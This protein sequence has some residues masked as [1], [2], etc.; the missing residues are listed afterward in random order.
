[1]ANKVGEVYLEIG[2]RDSKLN[3]S[4]S[5]AKAGALSLDKQFSAI[6]STIARRL[7]LTALAAGLGYVAVAAVKSAAAFEKAETSMATMLGSADRARQMMKDLAALGAETPLTLPG[8][9]NNARLLL[10]FG[11]AAEEIIPTLRM[12]GDVAGGDEERMSR[13]ALAFGQMTSTGRLMGQDLLQMINSGFNPLQ[14]ISEKT[15]ESVASLKKKM[16]EGA[17]SSKMVTDAFK[18]VTSEGGKF[19]NMMK[20]QSVTLSGQFSTLKD[21]IDAAGRGVMQKLT[22]GLTMFTAA[23]N[24]SLQ[25]GGFF[26]ELLQNIAVAANTLFRQLS[27]SV[28]LLDLMSG[29]KALNTNLEQQRKLV[30]EIRVL[31]AKGLDNENLLIKSKNKQINQLVE[32]YNRLDDIRN[33]KISDAEAF[34][35]GEL[36]SFEQLQKKFRDYKNDGVLANKKANDEMAADNKKKKKE[37]EVTLFESVQ[38]TLSVAGSI[39]S[40]LGEVLS[41]AAANRTQAIENEANKHLDLLNTVYQAEKEKIENNVTDKKERDAQLKALDEKLAR[42]EK[43]ITEKLDKDKRKIA[44]EAAKN[45]KAIATAETIISTA[46]AAM[47]AASSLSKIPYV[48][49]ALAIAAAAAI[50]ALGA[51]KIAL[52]QS[53][54]LPAAAEGGLVLS[55]PGGLGVTVAEAGRDE[56]L[57]PLDTSVY[58]RMAT[59]LLAALEEHVGGGQAKPGATI[60]PSEESKTTELVRVAPMSR[61]AFFNELFEASQNGELFIA[62]RGVQ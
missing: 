56:A 38:T 47:G 31:R 52:I 34:R 20:A 11:I 44:R 17:I 57:L 1:M 27:Q 43:L 29:G 16:E 55:R 61:E 10:N 18:S 5:A 46:S 2:A 49:W 15:G 3:A 42:E 14:A 23:M 62:K 58:R 7:T 25:S 36:T 6:G 12:L 53:Q 19:Y 39:T 9:Q 33:L 13:L 60:A 59:G 40:G 8:L 48:G 28:R 41:M 45:N 35:R 26:M 51:T 21:N 4:L 37:E 54:P 30:E 50:T 22:P 32:E 24:D